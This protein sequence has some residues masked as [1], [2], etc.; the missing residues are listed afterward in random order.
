MQKFRCKQI[1]KKIIKIRIERKSFWFLKNVPC[2][3]KNEKENE[4]KI[5]AICTKLHA[6][7]FMHGW[8]PLPKL[9]ISI[10]LDAWREV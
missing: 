3:K 9:K 6:T 10:V 5:N 7:G 4:M 1:A 8:M 2:R